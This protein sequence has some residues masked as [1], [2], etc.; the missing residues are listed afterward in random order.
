MNDEPQIPCSGNKSTNQKLENN[1]D[2]NNLPL[3]NFLSISNLSEDEKKSFL[4][5][6]IVEFH[7]IN[8]LLFL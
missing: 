4:N 5:I 7:L 6:Q 2:N 1:P 3:Y 8:F